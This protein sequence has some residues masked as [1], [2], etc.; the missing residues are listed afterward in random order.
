V[1]LDPHGILDD[2][3]MHPDLVRAVKAAWANSPVPFQVT[4]GGRT[5]AQEDALVAEGK[6]ETTHSRH[7][8]E[9]NANGFCCAVDFVALNPDGSADWTV[10]DPNSGLYEQIGS[11]IVEA[12]AELGIQMQWGGA[13]V[14]AWVDGVASGFHD[15]D[16]VQLDPS[17]YP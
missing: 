14:G 17:A 12:G 10:G 16:H 11:R 9:Q 3:K 5:Q 15:W 2:P 6:S 13:A 8:Y 7:V 4:Q 1:S